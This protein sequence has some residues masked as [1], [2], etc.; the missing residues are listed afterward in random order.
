MQSAYFNR[1][2]QLHLIYDSCLSFFLLVLVRS[3]MS[4]FYFI[5]KL[6][7]VQVYFMTKHCRPY[8]FNLPFNSQVINMK[9]LSKISTYYL[10]NR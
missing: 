4:N 3:S 8:D 5:V 6:K 7:Q 1:P 2:G 9:V 10:T